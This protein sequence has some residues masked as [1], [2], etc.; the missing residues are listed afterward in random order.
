MAVEIKSFVASGNTLA[1]SANIQING[2]IV[3]NRL[4]LLN[5]RA[6]LQEQKID[7]EE[8]YNA[9]FLTHPEDDR[10]GICIRNGYPVPSTCKWIQKVKKI[11]IFEQSWIPNSNNFLWMYGGPEKGKTY[12]PIYLASRWVS[13]VG[14]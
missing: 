8:C 10:E 2:P 13:R 12:L 5:S 1:G 7:Q 4:T 11:Q 3:D 6:V 14:P 9:L